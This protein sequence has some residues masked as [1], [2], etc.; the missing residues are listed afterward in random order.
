MDYQ[1]CSSRQT[2]LETLFQSDRDKALMGMIDL[3]AQAS[4]AT[5]H[6]VSNGIELWLSNEMTEAA[7]EYL[8]E[9]AE[10]AEDAGDLALAKKFRAW[11][12][13]NLPE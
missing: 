4:K 9:K 3:Y 2:E 11:L 12:A 5:N 10:R 6:E 13:K 1:E 8:S 7:R